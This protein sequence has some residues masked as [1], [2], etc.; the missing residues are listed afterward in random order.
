MLQH[1][2]LEFIGNSELPHKKIVS[3]AKIISKMK[4]Y[5]EHKYLPPKFTQLLDPLCKVIGFT[6]ASVTVEEVVIDED[7]GKGGLEKL[8]AMKLPPEKQK[9]K[10]KI[11]EEASEYWR[12]DTSSFQE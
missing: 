2:L 4:D 8:K 9:V 1:H 6:H 5:E 11:E 12:V 10:T 3:Y 7:R